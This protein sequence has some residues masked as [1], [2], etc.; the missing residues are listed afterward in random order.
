MTEQ[1]AIFFDQ[2]P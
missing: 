1:I 2:H